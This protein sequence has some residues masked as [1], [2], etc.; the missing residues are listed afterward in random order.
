MLKE[1]SADAA[2]RHILAAPS[3]SRLV[4]PDHDV[5]EALRACLD[6]FESLSAGEKVLVHAALGLWN[7]SPHTDSWATI[8]ALRMLDDAALRRVLEAVMALRP[9]VRIDPAE[10]LDAA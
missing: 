2:A 7:G 6:A 10:I 3:L 9:G 8:A 5:R 1:R 4:K